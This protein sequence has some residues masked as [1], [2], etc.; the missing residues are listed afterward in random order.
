MIKRFDAPKS[1]IDT[2]WQWYDNDKIL[3]T[4]KSDHDCDILDI[5]PENQ[6]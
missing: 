1:P 5:F 4:Q 2:D 6:S 3:G